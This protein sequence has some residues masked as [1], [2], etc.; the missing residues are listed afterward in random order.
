MRSRSAEGKFVR[1]SGGRGQY[2]H[3]VIKLE[4]TQ[5]PGVGYDVRERDRW[6]RR[7]QGVHPAIDKGI[8]EALQLGV[9]AGFPLSTLRLA[10][11]GSYHEVDSSEAA[12]KVAGSMAIK[13]ALKKSD[14][15]VLEPSWLSRLRLLKS[16]SASL[17]AISPAVVVSSRAGAA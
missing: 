14:P 12:F 10:F 11:D 4:K 2:G 15:A 5:E 7:A 6:R 8:Q 3:A 17:W 16:T 13:D 1:Q 9:M